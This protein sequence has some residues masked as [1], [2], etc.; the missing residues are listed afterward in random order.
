MP[1]T[2]IS[3]SDYWGELAGVDLR[4]REIPVFKVTG[5]DYRRDRLHLPAS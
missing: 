3:Y 2:G 5:I 4:F 1:G